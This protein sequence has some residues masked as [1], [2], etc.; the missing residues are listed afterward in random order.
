MKEYLKRIGFV[1]DGVLDVPPTKPKYADVP[2]IKP[3]YVTLSELQ[4][5]HFLNVP[6]E[7]LDILRNIPLSLEI[8]DLY[9]KIVVNKR[10][11]YCFELNALF[12]WLLCEI[13]FKTTN[14]F[15]RFLLDEP[16]IPMRRH[17]VIR[18]DIDGVYYLADVGVGSITPERPLKLVENEETEI[19]GLTYKLNKEPFLGWVLNLKKDGKWQKIYSFTE[20]QQLEVDY[21][22][23]NFYCQHSP[24]SIFN[25]ENMVAIRTETGKYT[26]DGNVFKII[27]NGKITKKEYPENEIPEILKKYFGIEI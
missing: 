14:Y 4:Y 8:K 12:N 1:G 26:L 11:G 25:K 5:K 19:R 22:Q 27:D 20:E 7:N 3:D 21:I 23:P 2:P 10:G 17:R 9:E 24:D 15:A 16:T 18:V 13:G 6:Y